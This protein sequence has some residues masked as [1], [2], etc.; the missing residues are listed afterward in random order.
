MCH[1][2][3]SLPPLPPVSGGACDIGDTTLTASDGN[4]LMAYYAHPDGPS[5]TGM[6]VMPDVRGLQHFYKDLARRFAEAGHHSIA[7]DYFGRTA[8][9]EDR[10]EDFPFMDHV[11]QL[12]PEGVTADVGAA[13]AWLRSPEGGNVTSIFTVG[14]CMGGALSWAQSAGGHGLAGC[15]GFYGMPSRVAD[16]VSEMSAPLL[17]LVAGQ[18]FTPLEEFEKFSQTLTAAGVENEMHVYPDAPHSYFDRAFDQH[19]EACEDSWR[20]V[21]TFMDAHSSG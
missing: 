14:F 2:D 10:G 6:I 1:A 16:R 15:V 19:R 9:T 3:D 4:R 13:A 20:R 12:K 17:L 7:V 8:D 21:L 11:Q 5:T 18:D